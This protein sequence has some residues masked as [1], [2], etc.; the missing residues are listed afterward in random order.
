MVVAHILEPP[1]VIVRGL[2][3]V[4][5]VI[6]PGSAAVISMPAVPGLVLPAAAGTVVPGLAFGAIAAPPGG[7]AERRL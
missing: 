1:T 7:G 5:A 2:L 3:S 6:V 4:S